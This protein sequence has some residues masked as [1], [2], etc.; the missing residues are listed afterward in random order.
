VHG[1]DVDH[2]HVARDAH[3]LRVF[4]R[5]QGARERGKRRPYFWRWSERKRRAA[6]FVAQEHSQRSVARLTGATRRSVARWLRRHEFVAHV[7]HLQLQHMIRTGAFRALNEASAA[8]EHAA[9]LALERFGHD[10]DRGSLELAQLL[11]QH[12]VAVSDE[13]AAEGRVR[14]VRR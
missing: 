9:L 4:G 14:M 2:H 3:V 12:A 13:M 8:R 5:Q 10:G 1:Q 6:E 11:R 7:A